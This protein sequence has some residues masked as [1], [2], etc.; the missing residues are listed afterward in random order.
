[1]RW[2]LLV[3]V[4]GFLGLTAAL[5][6][7]SVP[8]PQTDLPLDKAVH[9]ALFA[10]VAFLGTWAGVPTM[11]LGALLLLQAV[12][13][14]VVQARLLDRRGGDLLDLAADVLGIALGLLAARALRVGTATGSRGRPASS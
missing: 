1:M 5:Y 7:P 13:S 9:L 10:G 3:F 2:R 11:W 12:A 6:W 14:E 4:L 8:G